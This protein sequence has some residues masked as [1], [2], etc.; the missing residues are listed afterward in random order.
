MDVGVPRNAVSHIINLSIVE[1]AR[2][3][4]KALSMCMKSIGE[5]Q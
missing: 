1:G 5:K 3:E 2:M 4:P